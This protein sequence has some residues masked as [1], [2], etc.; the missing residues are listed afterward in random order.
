MRDLNFEQLFILAM[1]LLAGLLN[2]VLNWMRHRGRT[3]QPQARHEDL[4]VDE[5]E[6][7]LGD[8]MRREPAAA[9]PR[10][11]DAA[12]VP[13]PVTLP[14]PATRPTDLRPQ[15]VILPPRPQAGSPDGRRL[16]RRID[17]SEARR[18][19]VL[20]TILGPCRGVEPP[21]GAASGR[22]PRREGVE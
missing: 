7:D 2:F 6:I 18:G 8:A 10:V 22:H 17:P 19:V 21:G 9:S 20:M 11:P 15:V 12:R 3:A 5:E 4:A 1:V 14:A 16:R 13:M